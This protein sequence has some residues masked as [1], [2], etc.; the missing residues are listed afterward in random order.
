MFKRIIF[1]IILI[2]SSIAQSAVVRLETVLGNIDIEM[3]DDVAPLTVENF[4]NYVNDGDFNESI[5]HRALPGFILQGGIYTVSNNN[6]IDIPRDSAVQNEFNL[7]N[8]RGTVAMAKIGGQPNSATSSFFINTANNAANLDNQNGGFTVFG[9]V[10]S[11]MDIVDLI[12]SLQKISEFPLLNYVT[13]QIQANNYVYIQKAYVLS[14]TFQI[15]AGLSGAWV[16]PVTDGQGLYLEVLPAFNLV[17]VGWYTFDVNAPDETVP[18]SVGDAS[19]RWLTAVG[20]FDENTFVGTVY[21]TSGGLFD[22]P[23]AVSTT[24]TGSMSIVF[25]NCSTAVFSYLLDDSEIS[26]T[27]NIQRV[28]GANIALCEQ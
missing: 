14:D 24:A 3:R 19:N 11:G 15:N 13:G 6:L 8:T 17:I 21:N 18:S 27:M 10:I 22:N 28:S 25:N 23:K 1:S 12:V 7:S 2:S 20:N 4:L 26:N 5:F 16:N 9:E